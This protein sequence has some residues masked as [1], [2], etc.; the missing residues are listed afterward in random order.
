M[1]NFIQPGDVLTLTAPN[2]GV[3]AGSAYQIGNLLVVAA[4]D[5]D[6]GDPF[7][8]KATG[9]FDLPKTTSET[10]TEGELLYWDNSTKKLTESD[11]DEVN[12]LV[13]CAAVAAGSSDTTGR[14]RLN[15][16]ALPAL[17]EES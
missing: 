11:G 9:V 7:E 12:L 2:G 17:Y 8:G 14:C 13:G 3:V 1:N 6:A 16:I 4:S 15:G 5:A 10:W